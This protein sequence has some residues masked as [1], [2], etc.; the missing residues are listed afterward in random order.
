M[1]PNVAVPMPPS[2]KPPND[3]AKSPA[4]NTSVTATPLSYDQVMSV[5][6]SS[7]GIKL[8]LGKLDSI[9]IDDVV[10]VF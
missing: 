2:V 9:G 7:S 1:A 8:N 10:E 4:P 5:S 3:K 6:N